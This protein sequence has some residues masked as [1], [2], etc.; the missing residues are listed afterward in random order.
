MGF[1]LILATAVACGTALAATTV[2]A[3][4]SAPLSRAEV[5]AETRAAAKAGQLTPAGQG[6]VRPSVAASGPT[7]TRA[8]RKAAV[9][10]ARRNGTLAPPGSTQ[11]ADVA[12]QKAPSTRS[13]AERKA[14]TRAEERAGE[15]VPA[16]QGS[17]SPTPPK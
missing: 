2:L 4:A 1:N 10:E 14:Q 13:R 16:G 7:M 6:G 12:I 17:P 3:Q 8:Q 15:M 9:L 5:K 11:K